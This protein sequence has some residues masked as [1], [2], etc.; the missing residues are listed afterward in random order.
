MVEPEDI[1]CSEAVV[2]VPA[3]D[4]VAVTNP[5]TGELEVI[6]AEEAGC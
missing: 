5:A 1:P 3:E 6:S 4:D 2:D